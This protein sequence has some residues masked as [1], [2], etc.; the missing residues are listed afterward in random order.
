MLRQPDHT[1]FTLHEQ[2]FYIELAQG[3][4]TAVIRLSGS[5][6]VQNSS[7]FE[8]TLLNLPD[9]FEGSAVLELRGLSF[10][11]VIGLGVIV[12]LGNALR[13]RGDRL[14]LHGAKPRI[15]RLIHA[16]RLDELFAPTETPA[17]TST[18]PPLEHEAMSTACVCA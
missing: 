9:R 7:D 15:R 11:N 12:R 8:S 6:A 1:H 4:D 17:E 14:T 13:N 10:I 18:P 5:V 2:G 3:Q 16:V